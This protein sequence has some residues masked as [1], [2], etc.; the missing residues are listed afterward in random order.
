MA[1]VTTHPLWRPYEL[2]D[3]AEIAAAR[4]TARQP[5][6][7]EVVAPDPRW[8]ADF[9]RVRIRIVG[10]LGERALSV[11]HVGSTAV[12]GLWAKPLIDVDLV[13][14]APEVEADWLGDLAA[15]GFV[16]RVREPENE[17]HRML[18]GADPTAN[19]HVHPPGARE[20]ARHLLFRDWLRSHPADRDAYAAHKREVAARGFS[21]S[22]H[23]NNAKAGPIYDLYERIL[24]ADPEHRHDPRPRV[25]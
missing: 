11:E 14:V 25:D 4:V 16:L 23:Y 21:D 5:E 9:E 2:P 17:Q 1:D 6:T 12:P 20:P 10:A 19:L 24:A 22:M 15:A 8:P 7:V 18:R 3:D 13:V